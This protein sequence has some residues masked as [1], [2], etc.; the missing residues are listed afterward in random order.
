M[1]YANIVQISCADKKEAFC[2]IRDFVC[3]RNGTYNYSTTGIGWTLWDSSY[4]VDENN[5]AIND[6]FV[7]KSAGE[8]TKEDLYFKFT[9]SS[10][11]IQIHGFQAWDPTANTGGNQYNAAT[12]NYA[13]AEALVPQ[14]WVYGDLDSIFIATKAAADT[15]VRCS[16]FGKE[17]KPWAYL[18]DQVAICSSTLTAGSDVSITVDS[19]PAGWTVG[20]QLFIRTTHTNATNTVKAEKI[21]IKTLSGNVITADLANSYTANSKLSDHVGYFCQNAYTLGTGNVLIDAAGT[22]S[23]GATAISYNQ[24]VAG[25][26]NDP[27]G[28]ETR[29]GM[30]EAW[31]SGTNGFFGK[32]KNIYR[33][34][35]GTLALFDVLQESAGTQWRYIKVYSNADYVFKEV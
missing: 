12:N 31:L 19:V 1:A 17:Q 30:A 26:N 20:R 21:T 33:I 9:W 4:A 15:E 10:G 2:R 28:Y 3:K 7:I 16:L 34:S 6:W 27:G 23:T 14:L 35:L 13:V 24:Q 18:D 29:Y 25:V 11:Y 22:V 32:L 8:S 5:P